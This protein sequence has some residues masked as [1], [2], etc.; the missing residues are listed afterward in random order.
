MGY[1]IYQYDI[2]ILFLK[3]H[4]Q[5]RIVYL[6]VLEI[7]LFFENEAN[8]FSCKKQWQDRIMYFFLQNSVNTDISKYIGNYSYNLF[9]PKI[10]VLLHR[11]CE[12]LSIRL[13][14]KEEHKRRKQLLLK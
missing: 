7:S 6:A 11:F 5:L 9:R 2:Y 8:K 13:W 14:D 10:K 3:S 1:I 4:F 12:Q